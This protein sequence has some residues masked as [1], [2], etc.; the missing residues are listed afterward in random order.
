MTTAQY[1]SD[2]I[3]LIQET[4][5]ITEII[6]EHVTLKKGG[7][8][9]KGLC[10]FHS[11]KTAS[12]TVNPARKFFHCFGCGEGG[13]I[14]TFMMKFHR[15]TFPE[16]LK[17]LAARY[18]ID[19]PATHLS[20]ADQVKTKKRMIIHEINKRAAT[21]YHEYLLTA[22]EAVP[23]RHY[24]QNRGLTSSIIKSFQLGYAPERWDFIFKKLK[25]RW[26]AEEIR[27][28]GLIISKEKTGYYDR[29][30]NRIIFPVTGMTGSTIGFG[31]RI[32]GSSQP[33]YIN[34]PETLIFN[35]SRT[36]FGLYQNK[37]AIRKAKKCI[38]VEGNF[39]LLALV[40]QEINNVAA[41][42][43]TALTKAHIR[44][45]KGYTDQIILLFDGDTAGIRAAM[46]TVAIFLSEQMDARI[47]VLPEQHDP[48]TFINEE[49][50]EKLAKLL[51]N[52]ISLPEFIFAR[53]V[54]QF[55]LTLAG[56][57]KII[58]E[59]QPFIRAI[60]DNHLQRTLFVSHFST[61]L[62]LTP[63]QLLGPMPLTPSFKSVKKE[64]PADTIRLPKKQEQLLE[65][66]IV[67]PEYLHNFIEAGIDQVI[68]NQDGQ[69]ILA[70]LKALAQHKDGNNLDELLYK[71]E[72]RLKSFI[73]RLLVAT[74]PY[75]DEIKEATAA[76]ITRWLVKNSLKIKS[77]SLLAQINEAHQANNETLWMEL[78]EQKKKID[79]T[80][81]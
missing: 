4:A 79:E 26:Q 12:F 28:A 13:D 44:S 25:Q 58:S 53:L 20:P 17:E 52:A 38:I 35:K 74:P 1:S 63:E 50:K 80:V 16:A 48:D 42:L 67:Y 60:D 27:E 39:D 7:A 77:K 37:E 19:L 71:T 69:D 24:L 3:Q 55:G 6:G 45:L 11:E 43:G 81:T 47:A 68:V 14:F 46:R 22:A 21:V 33:K 32:L 64:K 66:L 70:H 9:L 62:G 49:G 36:L 5:D 15:L 41:P 34:T 51:I 72:G 40:A 56:K 10:P 57:G 75:P 54:D 31:G 65:F 76:E 78:M 73:S 23:A 29:F 59:L 61:K 2:I 8:N 30:R 18:Q